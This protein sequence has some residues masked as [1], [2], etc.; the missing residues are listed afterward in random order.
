MSVELY[1]YD[2]ENFRSVR[3]REEADAIVVGTQGMGPT[4]RE[5]WGATDYEFW[6]SVPQSAWGSLAVALIREFL[7]DDPKATD[8]LR[9]ICQR[10]G[11][12]HT[13]DRWV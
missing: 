1:R 12:E 3:V 4:T 11:V 7:T 2:G 9:D 10:Y 6:T 13:W 8:R 5:V